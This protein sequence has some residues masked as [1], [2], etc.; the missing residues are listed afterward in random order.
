MAAS[1]GR[2]FGE[3]GDGDVR[4]ALNDNERRTPSGGARQR[5]MFRKDGLLK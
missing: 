1:P 4:R 3:Q 2:G 5:R